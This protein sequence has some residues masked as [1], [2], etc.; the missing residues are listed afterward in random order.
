MYFSN[1]KK[2]LPTPMN[3]AILLICALIVVSSSCKKVSDP[4]ETTQQKL[5]SANYWMRTSGKVTYKDSLTR[6]D[7]TRPSIDSFISCRLDNTLNFGNAFIGKIILG[8]AHCE[9]GEPDSRDFSW[10]CSADGKHLS[11]YGVQEVFF[12]NNVEAEILNLSFDALSLRYQ[13][14]NVDPQFQTADTLIYTDVFRK[15]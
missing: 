15:L 12:S 14:I 1:F 2:T 7:S 9:I 13:V 8:S 3:R 11:M 4:P 5:R 6:G 10:N